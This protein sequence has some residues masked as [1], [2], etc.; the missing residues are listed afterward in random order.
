MMLSGATG[1]RAC[2]S[3]CLGDVSPAPSLTPTAP[4]RW[5][6]VAALAGV[7]LA[8]G[9]VFALLRKPPP[10]YRDPTRDRKRTVEVP[11]ESMEEVV[12]ERRL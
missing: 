3:S 2:C 6:L 7:A 10:L 12:D 9:A 11:Y 1:Q 5:R 8:A 4:S